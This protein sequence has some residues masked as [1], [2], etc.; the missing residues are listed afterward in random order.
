MHKD[1][2]FNKLEKIWDPLGLNLNQGFTSGGYFIQDVI[3]GKLSIINLNSM[4]FF[5]KNDDVSDCG[6]SR[7]PSTVQMKWLETTLKNIAQKKG[8]HQVYIM[9]HV[10]PIDDDGSR[11]FKSNCYSQYFNL[12]GKYGNVISG[13]FTGHTNSKFIV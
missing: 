10:P 3:P 7:S 9:G 4:Y 11:L 12:L 8:E 2:I 5:S 1:K 6:S 13:H